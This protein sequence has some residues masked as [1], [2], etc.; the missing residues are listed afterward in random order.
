MQ[1][2]KQK[3]KDMASAAK[4]HVDIY[5]AKLEEKA[6]KAAARTPEEKEMAH[7]RRKMKEAQAKMDL[8]QAKA[9]HAAEK[10]VGKQAHV[11]GHVHE[12][13]APGTAHYGTTQPAAH[14]PVGSADP[15]TGT[16]VPT[17]P[18]GGHPT[19]RKYK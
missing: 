18:L 19:G 9:R 2:G 1:S 14:Q 15:V 4:E 5:E 12:P 3:I 6:E 17:Y 11:Y 7:E 16:A 8:H 10:L 13:P